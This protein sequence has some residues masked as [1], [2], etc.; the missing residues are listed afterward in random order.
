MGGIEIGEQRKWQCAPAVVGTLKL[1]RIQRH[2]LAQLLLDLRNQPAGDRQSRL[3][4]KLVQLL[5]RECKLL[6]FGLGQRPA[7]F[8]LLRG[9]GVPLRGQRLLAQ[10]VVRVIE[11]FPQIISQ[12]QAYRTVRLPAMRGKILDREGRVLAENR[13]RYNLSLYLDDL[14][15]PFDDAYNP[16]RKQALA[17]QRDTIAAQEKKLGRR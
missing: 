3:G 2:R 11:G 16:L 9:D 7:Q 17:A 14:R 12:T 6:A 10:R 13:P 5:G 1:G 4:V 15:K 8:F